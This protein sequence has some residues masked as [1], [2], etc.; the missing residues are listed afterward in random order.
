[1]DD[2]IVQLTDSNKMKEQGALWLARLDRGLSTEEEVLLKSW[3]AQ[4]KENRKYFVALAKKWDQLSV[5]SELAEVIPYERKNVT[6][7]FLRYA[8]AASFALVFLLGSFLFVGLDTFSNNNTMLTTEADFSHSYQ[9]SLGEKSVIQLPDSSILTLNTNSLVTVHFTAMSR[10]LILERG[11]A[12]IKVAHNK[13]RKLI[14][15]AGNKSFIAI[16]T[17]FNLQYDTA[18]DV[19]LI[20]TEGK[21]AIADTELNDFTEKVE[22][23]FTNPIN[24]ETLLVNAGERVVITPKNIAL[25]KAMTKESINK[26]LAW[27]KGKLIFKGETLEEV[28]KEMSR[29]SNINI[30]VKGEHL[31]N[32]RIGGRFKTGDIEGLL[33]VLNEQFNIKA[34]K[35]GRSNIQLT[36]VI[37]T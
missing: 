20:V 2:N 27:H 16:G 23:L 36:Q 10:K 13:K 15:S 12:H 25:N 8:K 35:M 34:K 18:L 5:L 24:K 26:T 4:S 22:T 3:L 29:Y 21:V 31:K 33:D 32:T 7:P 37:P 17:A 9:T 19:E 14:F 6:S 11:E 1:M 28:I 30:E